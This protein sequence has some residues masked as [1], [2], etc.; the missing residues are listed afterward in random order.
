MKIKD[1]GQLEQ[2]GKDEQFLQQIIIHPVENSRHFELWLKSN[3][4]ENGLP[5]ESLSY[6]T[7]DELLDLQQEIKNCLLSLTK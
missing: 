1:G 7:I 3:N 6:L 2:F 4:K 5:D